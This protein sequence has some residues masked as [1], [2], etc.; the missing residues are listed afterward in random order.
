V[1][2]GPHHF[3]IQHASGTEVTCNP[4]TL[5]I[6]AC[7]DALAPC[8]PYTGGV[9]G[10]LS[11]TGAPTVNWDGTTGGAAGAGFDIPNGSSSVTKNVQ[12]TT[13][14]TTVF[15]ATATPAATA[16][17]TCNFGTPACTFT[18]TDSGFIVTAPDHAAETAST[19]TIQAVKSV[20]GNPLLCTTGMTGAKT[21]NLKCSYVNPA[22]GVLPV[23]IGGT[24][25]AADAVSACSAGGVDMALTFNASGVAAPTL[26]YADVGEM[27][28]SANFTGTPG[29]IDEGLVLTGGGSFI[30]A[31]A[32]FDFSAF[33]AGTL[34]AGDP[35]SATVR[36]LNAA[37][38]VAPNFGKESEGVTLTSS[39]VTPDPV[40][41]PAAS[42]PAPGNN[43]IPGTEFGAGG[44]VSDANGVATVDNLSWG[45]VGSITLTAN[46][47]S[48]SY[49]GSG[50]MATGTS[51]TVGPFIPHHFDTVVV[52]SASVPMPCPAG[53]TCPALYD[54][55]VYSGQPFSMQVFARNLA[56]GTTTNYDGTFGLSKNVTLTAWNAKGGATQNPGSGALGSN[57]V[58]AA[59]FS[60][61]VATL[62]DTPT[63]T[64]DTTPTAPTDIYMRAVD[65]D[66][67]TSLRAI[68]ANSVEGG[69]KVASGRVKISN[70]HGSELLPLPMTATVQYH[71]GAN[72]LTSLT[73]S[74]TSLT[75]GLSNY[76]CKTGCAWTTT[77]T[78]AGGQAIAGILS[79]KL[80]KPSGGGTGSVDVSIS[81]PGYLL[82]GSNG[83]AVNPSKAGRA[84]FG[85]YK[86][87]SEFIYL[88]ETY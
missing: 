38:A 11:A 88:R 16:A 37:G 59:A 53:L 44:M 45:E 23:R 69:V 3:E 40:T 5:T 49:L 86:G 58:A 65:T 32:S 76:Q 63:Y 61:G 28:I 31:P 21:V 48:G 41:Y 34:K 87:N 18:A 84:T 24:P 19:L 17:T 35:F 55:F 25:L 39:L 68:P 15:D 62:T 7:A 79:F 56:G 13:V 70:T 12:V 20:P 29:S 50:L 33:T 4:S 46:L 6:K 1:G 85:V 2:S 47:T 60:S 8:T 10:T 75:L 9:G 74:V 52:A 64:F 57:A 71:D 27:L 51:A 67:V 66:S 73:D 30:A 14:G 26:Q 22:S 82:A 54:G 83:A 42:N 43:A 81:A 36:A 78:P 72:W 77:P 80:S